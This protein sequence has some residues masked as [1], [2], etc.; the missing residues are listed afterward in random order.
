MSLFGEEKPN[1]HPDHFLLQ[2]FAH[3]YVKATA[4]TFMWLS[5]TYDYTYA[6]S[7]GR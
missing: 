3:Y 7:V 5:L 2:P 4:M 6:S 1:G